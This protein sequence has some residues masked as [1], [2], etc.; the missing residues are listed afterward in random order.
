M[1]LMS[2][3][4]TCETKYK[5]KYNLI[6][7]YDATITTGVLLRRHFGGELLLYVAIMNEYN[8]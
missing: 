6:L 8:V 4:L 7:I 5:Y 3:L 1:I 2:V